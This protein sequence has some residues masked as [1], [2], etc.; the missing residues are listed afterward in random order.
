MNQLEKELSSK[1]NRL[2]W[3]AARRM[4]NVLIHDYAGTDVEQVYSTIQKDLPSLKEAFV[5]IKKD[6]ISD[7]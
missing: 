7:C 3:I 5:A 6:L 4:R 2:P 1:Y